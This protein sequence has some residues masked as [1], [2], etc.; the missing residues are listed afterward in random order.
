[1]EDN[2]KYDKKNKGGGT[3]NNGNGQGHGTSTDNSNTTDA[4]KNN[5]NTPKEDRKRNRSGRSGLTPDDKMLKKCQGEYT[6]DELSDD[7]DQ[8]HNEGANEETTNDENKGEA[9]KEEDV[10]D[11]LSKMAETVEGLMTSLKFAHDTVSELKNEIAVL[12]TITNRQK[13]MEIEIQAVKMQNRQ[14][15]DKLNDMENYSRREN[16]EIVGV[17]EVRDENVRQ[18]CSTLFKDVLGITK[19]I[20]LDRCHR[21]G[22]PQ[23][24]TPR[25]Q[26]NSETTHRATGPSN[27]RNGGST[28]NNNSNNNNNN[29]SN[30][31]SQLNE[32]P[33]G[34]AEEIIPSDRGA[35]SILVRFKFYQDKEL[36]LSKRASLKQTGIFMNDDLSAESRRRKNSLLPLLHE[37]RT[38]DSRTQFRGDKISFRGRLYDERNVNSLPIDPHATTTISANG[39][40]TFAGRFSK[41]SNLHPC[42]LEIDGRTWSSVEQYVQFCKATN[43]GDQ[44]TAASILGT[45]DPIEAMT[46]GRTVDTMGTDWVQQS[47]EI[48]EKAL[49][50]KFQIPVFK[51]AIL[52]TEAVIGEGITDK[53]LGTGMKNGI[54]N[55][56]NARSWTGRNTMGKL[57]VKIRE[58]LRSK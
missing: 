35:R 3:V 4:A 47:E 26:H 42:T 12:K 7:D 15:K 30:Q 27:D 17:K 10:N 24:P 33:H 31:S 40:T 36:V 56:L 43:W 55:S 21:V 46:F 48:M 51:K 22:K 44:K 18:I 14:L 52:N 45:D 19:H 6:N 58:E 20:E 38:I 2:M 39:V 23:N 9:S 54:K 13:Q 29:E 25:R 49:K 32:Q 8:T 50:K 57:L 5:I 1:M 37:L 11:K 28:Q 34:N 41:L 53:T 16:M